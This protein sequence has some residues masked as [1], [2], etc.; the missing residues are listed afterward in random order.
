MLVQRAHAHEDGW[1]LAG[2]GRNDSGTAQAP[3]IGGVSDQG[4]YCQCHEHQG[5][6]RFCIRMNTRLVVSGIFMFFNVFISFLMVHFDRYWQACC[7]E[8]FW[9]AVEVSFTGNL[10]IRGCYCWTAAVVSSHQPEQ[11]CWIF[12]DWV[13]IRENSGAWASNYIVLFCSL[14]W[15]SKLRV[16]SLFK[17][18]DRNGLK[19][20]R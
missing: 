15:L 1:Q 4:I 7:K 2:T 13:C 16:I 17:E 5:I 3:S 11:T 14:P 6:P 12:W 19:M 8:T 10:C 20:Q 18:L 9:N